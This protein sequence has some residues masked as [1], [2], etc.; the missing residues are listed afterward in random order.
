[1]A[2]YL[3]YALGTFISGQEGRTVTDLEL[4]R[5]RGKYEAANPDMK[6][7]EEVIQKAIENLDRSLPAFGSDRTS[8]EGLYNALMPDGQKTLKEERLFALL[9]GIKT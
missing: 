1:M 2:Q 3:E 8:L 4:H 5:L 9:F 6:D 7:M